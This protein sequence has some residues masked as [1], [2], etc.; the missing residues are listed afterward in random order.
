M[1]VWKLVKENSEHNEIH[2]EYSVC[3]HICT[4][5]QHTKENKIRSSNSHSFLVQKN[6]LWWG[7]ESNR[8]LQRY[9]CIPATWWIHLEQIK[10]RQKN[11]FI[12]KAF[13]HGKYCPWESKTFFSLSRQLRIKVLKLTLKHILVSQEVSHLIS[14]LLFGTHL[15]ISHLTLQLS[16]F[17]MPYLDFSN[18]LS[19]FQITIVLKI[20]TTHTFF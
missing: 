19:C 4:G 10:A 8:H 2:T 9:A 7:Q 18:L 3:I 14:F 6:V 15:L 20:N 13:S 1:Y 12:S 5:N 16:S 17:T 11:K